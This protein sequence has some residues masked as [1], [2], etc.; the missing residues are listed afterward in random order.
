MN[1]FVLKGIAKFAGK[2]KMAVA[3]AN[4]CA[5][6]IRSFSVMARVGMMNSLQVTLDIGFTS[7]KKL[8]IKEFNLGVAY[9]CRNVESLAEVGRVR[10]AL[11]LKQTNEFG[12]VHVLNP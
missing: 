6:D 9:V 4:C 2:K 1:S 10:L 11:V 12:R 8:I 3:A 7:S 5:S